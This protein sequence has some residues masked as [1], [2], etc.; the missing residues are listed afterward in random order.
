MIQNHIISQSRTNSM[1]SSGHVVPSWVKNNAGWWAEN[2]ISDNDFAK[3]I[4]FLVQ[5]GIIKA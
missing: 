2:K 4:E 3:G 5:K 1:T